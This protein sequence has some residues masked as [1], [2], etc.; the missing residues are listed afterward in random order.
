MVGLRRDLQRSRSGIQEAPST[1]QRFSDLDG[2]MSGVCRWLRQ[3]SA[4]LE[5]DLFEFGKMR[6][7]MHEQLTLLIRT[8]WLQKCDQECDYDSHLRLRIGMRGLQK[9]V[10]R[11]SR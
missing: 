1:G 2:P 3:H 5:C 10:D 6:P 4:T 7:D 11:A 9:Y 8:S